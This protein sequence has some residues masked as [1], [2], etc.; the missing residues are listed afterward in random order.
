MKAPM[1]KKQLESAAFR[2]VGVRLRQAIGTTAVAAAMAFAMAGVA[3][4]QTP[5]PASPAPTT[6]ANTAT[7]T[8]GKVPAPA[9]AGTVTA[10]PAQV[11]FPRLRP[12]SGGQT[13]AAVRP[14]TPAAVVAKPAVPAT[15]G[16]V[17]NP[18]SKY[19]P[20]QQLALVR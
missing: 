9:A 14:S 13:P 4:A 1:A 18:N 20:D 19:T 12:G 15:P 10:T 6:P 2:T 5:P 7:P 3:A 16:F 8:P 11:P 17:A